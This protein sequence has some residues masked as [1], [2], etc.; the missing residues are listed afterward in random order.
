M[1][2]KNVLFKIQADTAQLRRELEGVKAGLGNIGTATKGAESQLTGLKKSLTGA[3]A[4]FG[5][6]SLAASAIDFGKGAI[7]AVSNY[8]TVQISLETFLG[9]AEKAKEVFEDLN[10]FSIKTPFTPEQVNQAGKALLAFGE[11]VDGLTTTLGRIGDVASATGKDFNELAVIYGKARVQGTLFAEDINQL[12]EAGVPIIGEFAKQLG[13]SESQVK[14]LGSE[15]QIS[16]QNLE[17]GFKSL[18]SEGGR[19]FGLTDK[20]SQ[21][22][23]GRLSTLVGKFDELKRAVGTG[24]LP[25]FET[26][27][28][29]LFGFI[30]A[31]QRIPAF[32]EENQRVLLLL[33]AAVAFYVGQ[34]KAA[35][36][37]Q[38]IYELRFKALLIQ[39]QIG[40]AVQ[41]AKAFL[42]RASTA[43]TNV[44]TGATTAQSIATRA[45]TIATTGF[46]AALKANPIGLVVSVLATAAALFVDFGD[47]VEETAV[48][49]EKLLDSQTALTTAQ[50]EANAE[51]AK[52]ISE[53]NKLVK[54][55]K[56]ANTGS[57]ERKKLIDQ[58]NNQYGTTIKNI[59]DEKKFIK[60]LDAEY[61]NLVN[62]IK[63]VAFAKAA[64]GQLVELTKQQLDLE[65]KLTKAKEAKATATDKA[66]AKNRGTLDQNAA[67]GKIE[68]Q[69]AQNLAKGIAGDAD[70][71][72]SQ[73]DATTKAIDDLSKKIV[74]SGQTIQKV[75]D[76]SAKSAEKLG[77]KRTELIKD[78]QREIRDLGVEVKQQPIEFIDPKSLDEQKTKIKALGQFQIDEINNT[79]KD[80]IDKAREA[81]T[82]TAGIEQQFI[83]VRR[84]QTLKVVNETNDELNKV[85]IDAAE[86]R[87]Q[88]LAEIRQVDLESQLNE[89]EQNTAEIERQRGFLIEQFAAARTTTERNAIRE[90]LNANL[91]D[92]KDSIQSEENLVVQGIESKRDA[93]LLNVKLTADERVLI[94]RQ[95]DLDILKARQDFNDQIIALDDEQTAESK[96]LA[97]ER[98]QVVLDGIEKVAKATVDLANTAL[99]AAIQETDGQI[100]AQQKRVD[101]AA[102]IAEKGNAELLQIEEDRLTALNE[103]KANFVRAQQA[104]AAIELVANS[105][106]AISKAAAEGGAAAPFT[107]AATLIALAAGLVAARAQARA[108]A[109]FATGGYTGDGGK[110]Q[111]AGIVHRGEFVVTKEKTQR[112]RPLLEAIHSG[113]DPMLAKG[114]NGQIMTMNNR[115]MDGKLDRIEKAIREQRGLNLSIDERGINGIVSNI[116]YKQNRISNKA[117]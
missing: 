93:E 65:D 6:V 29:A 87:N 58:L 86:K 84:L 115:S 75:D 10:Q 57:A 24:L 49:T 77:E 109:S 112:F 5:G 56:S 111:P 50:T 117:R 70:L 48:Q 31:I 68:L 62:S 64:E 23:A 91:V 21:S 61:Q 106:V 37:Q 42:T 3:A 108:A 8:E 34:Q 30:T 74:D 99:N 98:K 44:L 19:F 101:A 14:K 9:S 35:I 79:I 36:Q 104:L 103:K 4:A 55:I 95:A 40:L 116:Q 92:L 2:V 113:R 78:L 69:N 46:N 100:N 90:Q 89:A 97:D 114:L 105:A 73:Y 11:P 54:E 53:L 15:G 76:D 66:N 67:L 25:I 13:V 32:V 33:G 102:K 94:E 63:S 110:Y 60:Q 85:T 16:F 1:A 88:T 47:S 82:L 80:R 38:L 12:T 28:E 59:T 41:R 52:S 107:I 51:S 39:E 7:E 96:K 20:L 71:L 22:T 27:T 83:E 45:A 18:T 72:Q 26:L 43:A 81:G 17:D